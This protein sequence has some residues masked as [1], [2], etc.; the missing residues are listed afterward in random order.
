MQDAADRE[1]NDPV[2]QA[3]KGHFLIRGMSID[4][5]KESLGLPSAVTDMGISRGYVWQV[6]RETWSAGFVDGRAVMVSRSRQ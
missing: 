6:G 4:E 3:I 5:A 1:A 2:K